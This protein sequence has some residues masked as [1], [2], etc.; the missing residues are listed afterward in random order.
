VG[1]AAIRFGE[2]FLKRKQDVMKLI[3]V[4]HADDGAPGPDIPQFGR[5]KLPLRPDIWAARQ[6]LSQ[7][8]KFQNTVKKTS[9]ANAI[10][11]VF[12]LREGVLMVFFEVFGRDFRVLRQSPP[13]R[14]DAAARRPYLIRGIRVIRGKILAKMSDFDMLQCRAVSRNQSERDMANGGWERPEKSQK[15]GVRKMFMT[16]FF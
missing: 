4:P 5:A 10:W 7:N 16:P 2:H 1:D 14:P 9:F 15:D 13:S 6:R 8:S 11:G 3:R 12:I